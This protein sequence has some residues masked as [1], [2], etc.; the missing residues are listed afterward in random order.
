MNSHRRPL[1]IL[2]AISLGM[3][4]V[5]LCLAGF[6]AWLYGVIGLGLQP[7]RPLNELMLTLGAG[8][9]AILS[10]FLMFA[11]VDLMNGCFRRAPPLN[12]AAVPA[13]S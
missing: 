11:S 10:G 12:A 1:Q 3:P 7:D 6:G 13:S 9:G 5:V 4:G 8:G 2:F